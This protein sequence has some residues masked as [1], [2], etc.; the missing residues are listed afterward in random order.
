MNGNQARVS[1]AEV[2][3]QLAPWLTASIGIPKIPFGFEVEQSDTARLFLER[4]TTERALFPG[5]YDVGARLAGGWGFLRYAIAVQNGEPEGEKGPALRDP[6]Q[7]KDITAHVGVATPIGD[8]I[9]FAAGV[10]LLKGTGFQAGTPAT[11]DVLVW[12]DVNEDGVVSLNELQVIRG[13]DATPS[14]NFGR[15][16]E[17]VDVELTI[18]LAG[19]GKL[20]AYGEL[21]VATNLDRTIVLPSPGKTGANRDF[22]ELGYYAALIYE[23]AA[24]SALGVRYD[25]YDPDADAS[26]LRVGNVVPLDQTFSTLSIAGALRGS[27]GRLILEYEHNTNHSGRTVSGVPTNLGDDALTLRAEIQL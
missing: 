11:K 12:K 20:T 21:T 26:E 25:R 17:G 18:D 13:Q 4:S 23:P 8:R 16:G 27:H 7:A 2:A 14:E 3:Y 1:T 9:Q 5:E 6:N 10:S 22:R 24:W 15:N 19:R